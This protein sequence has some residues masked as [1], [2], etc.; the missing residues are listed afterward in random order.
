MGEDLAEDQSESIEKSD[1]SPNT[2][3]QGSAGFPA[4]QKNVFEESFEEYVDPYTKR[5]EEYVSSY[6]NLEIGPN[7]ALTHAESGVEVGRLLMDWVLNETP[8]LDATKIYRQFRGQDVLKKMLAIVAK[9]IRD[10]DYK[11][12][13]IELTASHVDY[14]KHGLPPHVYYY[15]KLGCVPHEEKDKL[16]LD[17]FKRCVVD[18]D[19]KTWEFNPQMNNKKKA[20]RFSEDQ[21]ARARA[22]CQYKS[23]GAYPQG[24]TY[25]W[26]DMKM[27]LQLMTQEDL[28]TKL[29]LDREYW[30]VRNAP[31]HLEP[32]LQHELDK[33][34]K[35]DTA[36]D[37][38]EL[39]YRFKPNWVE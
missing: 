23:G 27:S 9:F 24:D 14:K 19:H 7:G 25:K 10:V 5:F 31:E 35:F 16:Y 2:P 30:V 28:V 36:H 29:G 37:V 12:K 26:P 22:F 1:T 33:L 4:S 6:T 3:W 11:I 20:K 8:I 32:W 21:L 13:V 34:E 38:N 15:S 17:G 18:K 39:V